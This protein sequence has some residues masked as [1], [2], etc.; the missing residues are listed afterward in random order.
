MVDDSVA[1]AADAVV[2]KGGEIVQ[3]IRADAPRDYCKVP[4][5]GGNVIG[6]KT[7]PLIAD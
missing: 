1:A 3:L 5:S 4:Q 7:I 6:L 2:T